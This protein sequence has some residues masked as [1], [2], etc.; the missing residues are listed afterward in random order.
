MKSHH[1]KA[2]FLLGSYTLLSSF[3]IKNKPLFL[4]FI[5]VAKKRI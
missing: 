2:F 4:V 3:F 5:V 1:K